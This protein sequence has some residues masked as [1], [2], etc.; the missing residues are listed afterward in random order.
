VTHLQAVRDALLATPEVVALVGDRIYPSVAPQGVER[1]FVV[2]TLVS[3][4]PNHTHTDAPADLLEDARVQV[5]V[6]GPEY[7][8]THAV[9]TAL[10]DVLGALSGE[11][12][13]A[14]K[15]N[16]QDGYEDETA[17]HYVSADYF[18]HRTRG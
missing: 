17:L 12:V 16:E 11:P 9:S 4:V 3:A 8:A 1:P 6:Y 7:V 15:D 5:R 14:T 18:V 2:L 13:S 10:D